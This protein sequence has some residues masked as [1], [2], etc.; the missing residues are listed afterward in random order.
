MTVE[1][2]FELD[3]PVEF[4]G[5]KITHLELRPITGG[6]LENWEKTNLKPM[7]QS[8]KMLCDIT[9]QTREFIRKINAADLMRL[10]EEMV[11]MMGKDPQDIER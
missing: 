9:G 10:N 3:H 5:E 1:K 4:D 6:D 8:N 7:A 2:E 11:R